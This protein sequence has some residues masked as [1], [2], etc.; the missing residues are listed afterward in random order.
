MRYIHLRLEEPSLQPAPVELQEPVILNPAEAVLPPRPDHHG[1]SITLLSS[2]LHP[3]VHRVL[4]VLGL[5][6]R[7]H[8]SFV[9]SEGWQFRF[10]LD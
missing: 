6:S 9:H 3:S 4:G 2:H 10:C 5:E 1:G 8:S 7:S